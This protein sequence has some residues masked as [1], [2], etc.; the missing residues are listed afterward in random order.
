[1]LRTDRFNLDGGT[2]GAGVNVSSVVKAG[3]DDSVR[4]E[5]SYGRGIENY[6]NDAPVDIGYREQS[7]QSGPAN[8]R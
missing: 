7:D 3:K 1:V 2:V 4:L 8:T 6:M 5:V